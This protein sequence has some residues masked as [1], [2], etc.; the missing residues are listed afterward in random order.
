MESYFS[1]LFED[2]RHERSLIFLLTLVEPDIS[3]Q[4]KFTDHEINIIKDIALDKI[5]RQRILKEIKAMDLLEKQFS[6]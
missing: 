5:Y 6:D 1:N 4:S 2:V 3:K